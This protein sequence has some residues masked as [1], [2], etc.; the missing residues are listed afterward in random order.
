MA[1]FTLDTSGDVTFP[2]IIEMTVEPDGIALSYRWSDLSPFAQGYVEA[3]FASHRLV[4]EDRNY[5]GFSD[6]APETLALILRDCEVAGWGYQDRADIGREVW[7]ARQRGEYR[8]RPRPFPPQTPYLADDGKVCL[9]EG[10]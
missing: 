2:A 3:M 7:Q 6:L 1:G 9:R 10:R 8:D 4:R 5:A